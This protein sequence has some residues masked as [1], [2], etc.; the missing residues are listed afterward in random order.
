RQ[1]KIYAE[2]I[3][4]FALNSGGGWKSPEIVSGGGRRPG[5][6]AAKTPEAG[7]GQIVDRKML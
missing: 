5:R 4:F 6:W 7:H 1:I 3:P 2:K